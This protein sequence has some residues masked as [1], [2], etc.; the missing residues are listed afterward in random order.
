[1]C[2]DEA[3]LRCL[4]VVSILT[5]PEGRMR[6]LNWCSSSGRH[7]MFQSSPDPKAGCD[8]TMLTGPPSLPKVSI[9]TRPEGR[10][11]L[12]TQSRR[13]R[14][15]LTFQSSPDPKAGCDLPFLRWPW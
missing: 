7:W 1:M 15:F 11:R 8:T 13:S 6:R 4:A 3:F 10:M 9:L 12:E 14:H 5:R 2:M